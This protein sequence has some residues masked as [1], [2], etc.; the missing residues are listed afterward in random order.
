[1]EEDLNCILTESHAFSPSSSQ[2]ESGFWAGGLPVPPPHLVPK[3]NTLWHAI[4]KRA[5]QL[6]VAAIMFFNKAPQILVIITRF[7]SGI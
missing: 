4:R 6:T 1:M 3:V 5:Y 7:H 2:K